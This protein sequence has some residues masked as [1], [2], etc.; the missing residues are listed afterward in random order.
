MGFGSYDESE[1]EKGDEEINTEQT[2]T[3]E[4]A[5]AEGEVEFESEDSTEELVARLEDMKE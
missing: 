5:D 4:N 1:Q 3:V 2:V